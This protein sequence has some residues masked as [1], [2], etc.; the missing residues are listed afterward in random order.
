MAVV[1]VSTTNVDSRGL[2]FDANDSGC[3]AKNIFVAL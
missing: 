3:S 1:Y 2:I